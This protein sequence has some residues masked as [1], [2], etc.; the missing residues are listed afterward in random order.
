MPG[1]SQWPYSVNSEGDQMLCRSCEEIT[2][3]YIE[4]APSK[5]KVTAG[6][7]LDCRSTISSGAGARAFN[8]LKYF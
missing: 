7:S 2:F 3:P 6:V 1:K 5:S 8:R 4:D